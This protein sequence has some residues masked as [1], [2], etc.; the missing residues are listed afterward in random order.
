MEIS[1]YANSRSGQ[2]VPEGWS[3]ENFDK[4]SISQGRMWVYLPYH[5][6]ASSTGQLPRAW[7]AYE[8]YYKERLKPGDVIHHKNEDPLDDRKSNL[9]KTT[10]GGHNKTHKGNKVKKTC[11]YCG[12]DFL[13]K[14]SQVA[15]G[16]GKYCSRRCG[17]RGRFVVLQI[18]V[19]CNKKFWVEKNCY[20][21]KP[22]CSYK[23]IKRQGDMK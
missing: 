16:W 2:V 8:L 5:P 1:I 6:R 4:G 11:L 14:P 9:A 22:I 12:N 17:A 20:S 13:V 3:L 21:K 18:C 19:V 10:R 7:V 23:C 15:R